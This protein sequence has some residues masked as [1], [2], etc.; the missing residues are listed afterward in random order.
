MKTRLT[1]YN[2]ND[3]CWFL[4]VFHLI[5]FIIAANRQFMFIIFGGEGGGETHMQHVG[6]WGLLNNKC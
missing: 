6:M 3:E 1:T 4:T 2:C 5:K